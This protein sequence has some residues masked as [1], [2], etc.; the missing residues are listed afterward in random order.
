LRGAVGEFDLGAFADGPAAATG[1]VA[2]FEDGAVEACFAEFVGSSHAGDACAEDDYF[3][4]FAEVSRKLR[5]R[6]LSDGGHEAEGLHG[7][8]CS[9]VAADLGDALDE[10]TS[11]QAHCDGSDGL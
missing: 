3:F 11:G 2:G 4:P 8:K 6:R 10:D 5:K 9:G 1:A 7:C